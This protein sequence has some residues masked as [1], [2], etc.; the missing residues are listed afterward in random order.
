[1]TMNRE[2]TLASI[3]AEQNVQ[4]RA[5]QTWL[6]KSRTDHGEI[7][8]VINGVRR[9]NDS[10][11]DILLSYAREPRRRPA[12]VASVEPDSA[13]PAI[14][15]EIIT[16]NHRGELALPGLPMQIDLGQYRENAP[17]ASFEGLDIERFLD[18]C[19]AFVQA[20]EADYQHQVEL[21]ERKALV[22]QQV[23][24]KA[25]QVQQASLLYQVRS[26]SLSLHN[27]SLDAD[28]QQGMTVLGKS[29][30]QSPAASPPRG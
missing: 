23:Q 1:M 6:A 12:P 11:R 10:E 18:S 29:P 24:A 28:I 30:V 5:V 27:R 14:T 9:F 22:A 19:D 16:G 7:G 13:S 4:K 25:Q 2:H 21:T 8:A 20:V 3:A 15:P 26:E 17:L